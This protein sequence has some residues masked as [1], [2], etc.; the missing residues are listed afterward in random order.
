MSDKKE[1]YDT[2]ERIEQLRGELK[3]DPGSHAYVEL[4]QLYLEQ[5]DLV[6]ARGV[7]LDGLSLDSRHVAGQVMLAKLDLTLGFYDRAEPT[8][9]RILQARPQNVEATLLLVDLLSITERQEE[10]VAL[11]R[12]KIRLFS[13]S[14]FVSK[15]QEMTGSG[16]V[17]M[18][19]PVTG[20]ATQMS[21]YVKSLTKRSELNSRT[22]EEPPTEEVAAPVTLVSQ[23]K[24]TDTDDAQTEK[25]E[26]PRQ[27]AAVVGRETAPNPQPLGPDV[28]YPTLGN[29]SGRP[30]LSVPDTTNQI[31]PGPDEIVLRPMVGA[32]TTPIDPTQA[33]GHDGRSQEAQEQTNQGSHGIPEPPTLSDFGDLN[34]I[35]DDRVVSKRA[36]RSTGRGDYPQETDRLEI[37]ESIGGE[38]TTNNVLSS[39]GKPRRVGE[40]ERSDFIDTEPR[41]PLDQKTKNYVREPGHMPLSPALT[42]EAAR[43]NDKHLPARVLEEP[44]TVERTSAAEAPEPTQRRAGQDAFF[45]IRIILLC[46]IGLAALTSI[47]SVSQYRTSLSNELDAY[48]Q[49]KASIQDGNYASRKRAFDY[50]VNQHQLPFLAASARK[51]VNWFG[52]SAFDRLKA[53]QDAFRDRLTQELIYIY[54]EAGPVADT[55]KKTSFPSMAGRNDHVIARILAALKAGRIDEAENRLNELK[56]IPELADD[57]AWIAA[58]VF[59]EKGQI[60]SAIDR[61]RVSIRANPNHPHALPTLVKLTS[62]LRDPIPTLETYRRLLN[63]QKPNHIS[64]QIDFQAFRIRLGKNTSLATQRLRELLT[65]DGELSSL[66]EATIHQALGEHFVTSNQPDAAKRAFEKAI[67]LQKQRFEFASPLVALLLAEYAL[68]EAG[69]LLEHYKDDVTP[70]VSAQL[71]ELQYLRGFPENAITILGAGP[72]A[73]VST[74]LLKAKAHLAIA[75]R[76]PRAA[77]SHLN[78]AEQL[79]LDLMNTER[80][81]ANRAR[82]G[83][84][85]VRVLSRQEDSKAL[86]QLGQLRDGVGNAWDREARAFVLLAYGEGLMTRQLYQRAKTQIQSAQQLIPERYEAHWVLCRLYDLMLRSKDAISHCRSALKNPHFEPARV[87]MSQIAMKYGAHG[88]VIDALMPLARNRRATDASVRRLAASLI[89]G[90]RMVDLEA[91]KKRVGDSWNGRDHA[92]V[93]GLLASKKG[94][95]E[96]AK[97][98][99]SRALEAYPKDES[100]VMS[101]AQFFA[102]RGRRDLALAAL[103]GLSQ[104]SKYH[105]L[106]VLSARIAAEIGDSKA[107]FKYVK[108][109]LEKAKQGHAS[110]SSIASAYALKSQALLMRRGKERVRRA[111]IAS[112]RALALDKN[113]PD[114]I[115]AAALVSEAR[116]KFSKAIS[117]LQR[118]VAVAPQNA[119]GHYHLGRVL[120]MV[121]DAEVRARRPLETAI[122]LEPDGIWGHKAKRVMRRLKRRNRRR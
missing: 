11:L 10:A 111:H 60:Q 69:R 20:G 36:D 58:L 104:Q 117:W 17:S 83:L 72:F 89:A 118:L 102:S 59:V 49:I 57:N 115:L 3:R 92:F 50:F 19:Y 95:D 84:A 16:Q 99:L 30:T 65:R 82:I 24:K 73:D 48:D 55:S 43:A 4:A 108:R 90:G 75:R 88:D 71:A 33:A 101:Y 46:F 85:L 28:A 42:V 26:P 56:D 61:L 121:V 116:G 51:V 38:E 80:Q 114:T 45:A 97:S 79:Y 86:R 9:R 113:H 120:S 70:D 7:V 5:G 93:N 62:S 52:P 76:Q 100:V 106:D 6:S 122:R 103:N 98:E 37:D 14:A 110:P 78:A 18:S 47:F 22:G 107:V 66:Q 13:D 77:K 32:P 119:K 81:T 96:R 12:T 87:K 44:K 105:Q 31:G 64:S 74:R 35:S 2:S 112:R 21:R 63:D 29:N 94:D 67:E 41:H 53:D 27:G 25:T 68:D 40:G 23:L 54:G 1:P 109:G 34:A 8:L 39:G 15:L 91:L